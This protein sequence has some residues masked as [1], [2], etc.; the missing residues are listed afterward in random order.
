[1]LFVFKSILNILPEKPSEPL[2]LPNKLNAIL[3]HN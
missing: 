3:I 2:I 1:M